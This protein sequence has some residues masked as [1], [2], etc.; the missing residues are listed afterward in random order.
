MKDAVPASPKGT[1]TPTSTDTTPAPVKRGPTPLE[2]LN[3]APM[4]V[5]TPTGQEKSY[6]PKIARL[7]D[8]IARLSLLEVADL[9]ELLKKRLNIPDTPM[10][11]GGPMMVAGGAQA[12]A[13][14][15][16]SSKL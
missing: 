13:E 14:V 15:C 6:D 11:M 1:P 3:E 2:K 5:S 8:D 16:K 9:N 12:P 10:M 7:V 4:A